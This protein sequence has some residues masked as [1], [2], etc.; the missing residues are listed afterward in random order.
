MHPYSEY[1]Q[2]FIYEKFNLQDGGKFKND[3]R[4]T[5]WGRFLRKL[6][7]DELPMFYNLLKGDLKLVGPRPLSLHYFNLYNEE[8]RKRRLKCKPGLIPPYYADKPKTL[9]EIMK[10]ELKYLQSY[11]KKPKITDIKYFFQ[12]FYNILFKGARSS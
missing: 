1:L 8:L 11:E 3:F 6:W 9:D 5:Y 12:C 10:S 2:D 7:I 4:I